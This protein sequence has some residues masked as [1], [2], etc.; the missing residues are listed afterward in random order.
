MS[1][2]DPRILDKI[3]G[4]AWNDI[5]NTFLEASRQVLIVGDSTRAV[6]TT[7]YVKFTVAEEPS[8][9]VYCVT[10]IKSAKNIVFGFALPECASSPLLESAPP[11]MRYK[12]L[13][14]YFKIRPCED[15]PEEFASWARAAFD[16]VR[17][18]AASE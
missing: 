4:P 12:G 17:N 14:K 7:I 11:G 16:S 6:L 8:S 5:R 2:V 3:R 13:T 1:F 10:W 9:E 15:V 18:A